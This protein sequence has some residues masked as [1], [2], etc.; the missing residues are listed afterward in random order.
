[1]VLQEVLFFKQAT[2]GI[3]VFAISLASGITMTTHNP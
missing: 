3:A 1:M 2:G